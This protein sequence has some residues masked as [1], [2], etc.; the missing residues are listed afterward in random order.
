MSPPT[1]E[2]T[3]LSHIE[4][5]NSEKNKRNKEIDSI[6]SKWIETISSQLKPNPLIVRELSRTRSLEQLKSEQ[7]KKTK[8]LEQLKTE[9]AAKTQ[10]LEKLKEELEQLKSTLTK[11]DSTIPKDQLDNLQRE[12]LTKQS[13]LDALK[14]QSVANK[15]HAAD[16]TAQLAALQAKTAANKVQSEAEYTLKEQT[17]K[18]AHLSEKSQLEEK[19]RLVEQEK[20]QLTEKKH[21][22][23]N[24]LELKILYI[25]LHKIIKEESNKNIKQYINHMIKKYNAYIKKYPDPTKLEDKVSIQEN[26]KMFDLNTSNLVNTL[27]VDMNKIIK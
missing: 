3:I 18:N 16:I 9:L 10:E 7:I 2:G 20:K 1:K 12:I 15:E 11:E 4:M 22:E 17:A 19:L 26:D 21:K 27:L 13:E 23:F 14:A 25:G 5:S 8:E 24:L 6:H